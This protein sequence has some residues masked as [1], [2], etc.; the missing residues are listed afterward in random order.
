MTQ[1][2][3]LLCLGEEIKCGVVLGVLG[4]SWALAEDDLTGKYSA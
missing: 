1:S 4:V 3:S 2:M